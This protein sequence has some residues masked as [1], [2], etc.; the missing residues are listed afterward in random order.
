MRI[1][2]Q[3]RSNSVRF[4]VTPLIDI[5]FLLIIFFLV[6]THF[7]R[8]ETSVSIQLPEASQSQ[9]EQQ[10]RIARLV[11]TIH[12]DQTY[13]VGTRA[14][15]MPEVERLIFDGAEQ[16]QSEFYVRIRGDRSVPYRLVEPIMIACA[17]A[18]VSKVRFAVISK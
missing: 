13:L 2:T 12:A 1:P 7:V 3:Q 6:S 14:V 8:S 11:V 18:G 10:E 17:R 15:E 5:V 16:K 4:N 9:E